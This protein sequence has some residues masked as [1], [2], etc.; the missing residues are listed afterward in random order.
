MKLF[1]TEEQLG[2]QADLHELGRA[3]PAV[4]RRH[5]RLPQRAAAARQGPRPHRHLRGHQGD[6]KA[7]KFTVFADKL[8]IPTSMMFAR[9]GVHRPRGA[10]DAVP[11]GHR[12]R[13][14]G[15]RAPGAVRQ[16]GHGRHARRAEQHAVRPGQL[17]LGHAGLQ[18]T[19]RLSSAARRLQFR[20]GFYRFKPDGSQDGVPAL[21]RTTTP[22]ASA[23]ARRASSSA[24]R[25][26][27]TRASTCRSRTATTRRC[28]AGRRRWCCTCIADTHHVQADHRQ[29]SPGRSSRRLHR[30]GRPRPVHRPH[31]PAGIL[32]PHRLRQRADRPPGRHV[33]HLSRKGSDFHSTNLLNLLAS[34][35]EWMRPDHGRGRPRRQRLGDR[36]VRLHRAAQPDAARLQDRQGRRLRDANCATR[37]TAASTASCTTARRRQQA[38]HDAGRRH[39]GR[40]WSRR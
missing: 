18:P 30:R 22:G 4:G 3:R 10:A 23:S 24:R 36:L 37:S 14:Q 20:Q 25:P 33:R 6:G 13:R 1:V 19:P 35:D 7:D 12:R 15:R 29:G 38:A 21:D 31:L 11:Q 5:G 26:T 9:G 32:E 17:G 2:R 16:L 8:S 27:A 40:S 28:A 39:A 34:D